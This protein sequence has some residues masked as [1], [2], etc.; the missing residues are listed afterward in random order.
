MNM[1]QIIDHNHDKI[2]VFNIN[3]RVTMDKKTPQTCPKAV[4]RFE[5]R[6]SIFVKYSKFTTII[7]IAI[8]LILYFVFV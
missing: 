8:L 4:N 5:R 6:Y 2:Q 1:R 3:M 7:A